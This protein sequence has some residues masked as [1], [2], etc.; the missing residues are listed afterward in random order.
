MLF[1]LSILPLLTIAANAQPA[2]PSWDRIGR[3]PA[4]TALRVELKNN[5]VVSGPL[6]R[7]APDQLVLRRKSAEHAIARADVVKVGKRSRLRGTLIGFAVAFAVSAPIGAYAGPYIA[8]WGNPSGGV[9]LR[10]AAGWGVFFGGVGAGIGALA[11]AHP[12]IY[13]RR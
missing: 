6:V 9:R 4:G 2:D 10:H 11:A 12:T 7:S 8:D 1:R 5:G 13:H 3:L